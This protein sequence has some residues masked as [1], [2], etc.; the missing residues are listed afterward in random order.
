[1][2]SNGSATC[3]SVPGHV[4]PS[5]ELELRARAEIEFVGRFRRRAGRR[6]G[7]LRAEQLPFEEALVLTRG[8][9][10]GEARDRLQQREVLAIDTLER[11]AE[12][13]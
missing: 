6:A 12:L 9:I 3:A 11:V 5:L 7:L 13:S 10:L 8:I 4:S 2:R 1:M